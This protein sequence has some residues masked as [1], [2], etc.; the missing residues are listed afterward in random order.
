MQSVASRDVRAPEKYVNERPD[1]KRVMGSFEMFTIQ[2]DPTFPLADVETIGERLKAAGALV[3]GYKPPDVGALSI[4]ALYYSHKI[5]GIE[6]Q[7]LP[8][9]NLVSRMAQLARYGVQK[10]LG[11]TET[12]AVDLM[13]F[14]QA[15]NIQ[16]EPSI[17]FHELAHREGNG[18][19]LEEIAWFRAADHNQV[20]DWIDLAQGRIARLPIQAPR[21]SE[22]RNFAR[23]LSRWRKNYV[24]ALKIA[25]LELTSITPLERARALFQ[26]MV[27][28]FFM[29]GPAAIFAT[30]YFA[31]NSRKRRLMK[32]L[33]SD[34]RDC[35]IAGIKNA[36]WDI[37]H[38]SNFAAKI[39]SSKVG[40]TFYIFAT[41]DRGLA[42]IAPVLISNAEEGR[43]VGELAQNLSAWWSP[44]LALQVAND[45]MNHLRNIE[46]RDPPSPAFS[47]NDPI[48]T[49]I[50]EGETRIRA[51]NRKP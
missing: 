19:A 29:A 10:A 49:L 31:P 40:N 2:L 5:Q 17:A 41:A 25:E 6:T 48:Q 16:I 46:G 23:P 9:R 1:A 39:E 32:Q 13:A 37:T 26:W 35:A 44:K 30:M 34:D 7:L 45:L 28:E 18:I 20:K 43:Q 24:V 47:S 36:A 8:D 14:A 12:I 50:D 27:D 42:E 38:L 33:R 22:N 15:M 4:A 11:K 3:A 51:W 21:F